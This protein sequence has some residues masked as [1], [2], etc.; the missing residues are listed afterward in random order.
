MLARKK[1]MEKQLASS[2]CSSCYLPC[3]FPGMVYKTTTVQWQFLNQHQ[4]ILYF[5]ELGVLPTEHNINI[6]DNFATE[7]NSIY[8]DHK[9]I[10]FQTYTK[11]KENVCCNQMTT[12]VLS[13]KH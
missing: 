1:L 10:V 5:L 2:Q 13:I 3:F 4:T 12:K 6:Y 8:V 11:W 7:A 9:D